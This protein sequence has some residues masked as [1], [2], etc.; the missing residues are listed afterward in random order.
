MRISMSAKGHPYDNPKAERFFRTLKYEE[1]SL[2]QYH[3]FEEAEAHLSQF[4]ED[5]YNE[6]RLHSS[7]GNVPPVEFE[8]ASAQAMRC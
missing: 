4:I 8:L 6:K 3:T 7:L 5:V 1:V 2:K